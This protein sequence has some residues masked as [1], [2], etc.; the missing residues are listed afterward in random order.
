MIVKALARARKSANGFTLIEILLVL[1]IIGIVSAIAIP[2]YLGQR[3]R[4]RVIG[5]AMANSRVIAMQL[6]TYKSDN[7]NYGP[8]GATATWTY[9]AATQPHYPTSGPTVSGY[10][11]SAFAGFVPSGNSGISFTLT[12]GETGL[13][14]DIDALDPT[15]DP[16]GAPVAHCV[17]RMNQTGQEVFRAK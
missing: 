9:N 14:Y 13:T 5:D 17:Y 4:A 16:S 15:V 7:G 11:A 12:V 1:A 2:A 6:E 8:A 3:R 10:P